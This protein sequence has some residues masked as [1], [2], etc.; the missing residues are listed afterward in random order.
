MIVPADGERRSE[1]AAR[2]VDGGDTAPM[3]LLERACRMAPAWIGVSGMAVS[4]LN[5]HGP[6]LVLCTSNGLARMLE[7]LQSNLGEGPGIGAHLS[8]EPV[9]VDDLSRSTRWSQY[10]VAAVQAG[11]GAVFAF[12]LQVGAVKFGAMTLYRGGPGEL[13]H[14]EFL[15]AG[16]LCEIVTSLVLAREGN[17]DGWSEAEL[18]DFDAGWLV[19][20]QATGMVSAHLGVRIDAALARLR[21]HAYSS[22]QSL[23][24]LSADI[25]ARRARMDPD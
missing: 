17:G 10:S 3:V 20:H 4:L 25:V 22:G 21:A 2:L 13:G 7:D 16:A 5:G 18:K 24:E 14:H 11:A 1:L 8:G 23:A 12:P 9:L 19:I 6:G 15:D